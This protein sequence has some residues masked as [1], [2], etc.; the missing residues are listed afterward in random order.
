M[1]SSNHAADFPTPSRRRLAA[2]ALL[3]ALE[4]LLAI[5]WLAAIPADPKNAV[6]LGFS[7]SRLVMLI[8][9]FALAAAF[10][11]AAVWLRKAGDHL[12][13]K[14]HTWRLSHFQWAAGILFFLSIVLLVLT[15]L[16][17]Y[18]FGRY[19]ATYTRIRPVVALAFAFSLQLFALVYFTFSRG[20][21]RTWKSHYA[22]GRSGRRAFWLSAAV[23][24][25]VW[26][27]I[28]VTRI[29]VEPQ[30]EFWNSPELPVLG[31]QLLI[32]WLLTLLF[33][34]AYRRFSNRR[35]LLNLTA[36]LL[37]WA[38][39]AL[40]WHNQPFRGDFFLTQPV[41]PTYQYY[42]FSD[43]R[44]YDTSAQ[45]AVSGY[46]YGRFYVDKPLVSSFLSMLHLIAGQDFGLMARLQM[47]V[48]ALIPVLLFRIGTEVGSPSG[49]LMGALLFTAQEGNRIA[50]AQLVQTS[51]SRL[52]LSELPTALLLAGFT[53][54]LVRWVKRPDRR[55]LSMLAAG[56]ILGLATLARHNTWLMLPVGL[57]IIL[58]VCWKHR[59]RALL[60]GAVFLFGLSLAIA[61]W[62]V[63]SQ[64][65]HGT[66][67]YFTIPARGVI[68]EN[69]YLPQIETDEEP[70]T[71]VI[72]T[73]KLASTVPF[74]SPGAALSAAQPI[75]TAPT[76]LSKYG[77]LI[78]LMLRHY[79]HN[80]AGSV[81]ILPV[82]GQ[83]HDLPTTLQAPGAVWQNDWG[84]SLSLPAAIGLF[85]T[86]L[87]LSTGI[88]QAWQKSR[89]AG[90]TPLLVF[91]S[92]AGAT[93]VATTSG[94]RYLVQFSWVIPLY[95]G[96]GILWL[97][98]QALRLP[99]WLPQHGT[100]AAT[101]AG[102]GPSRNPVLWPK[103]V[104]AA[105]L[106]FAAGVWTAYGDQTLRLFR[107]PVAPVQIPV[108]RAENENL[109]AKEGRALYTQ[110]REMEVEQAGIA[111]HTHV[112]SFD[113]LN[114][115][116]LF[117]L[118]MPLK[119]EPPTWVDGSPVTV[120]G[121]QTEDRFIPVV[122]LAATGGETLALESSAPFP[123]A[124]SE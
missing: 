31:L 107:E 37:I 95:L 105:A 25:L 2:G 1:P 61:P 109:V 52:F 29:G 68:I 45:L 6:F 101:Q 64:Q 85:L 38:G 76:G 99:G 103:L 24:G 82:S 97:T 90:L 55:W 44:I 30:T 123:A 48:F 87:L 108:Q 115:D 119:E 92:Y 39:A 74:S 60:A 75:E 100:N 27:F 56:G 104:L 112:F 78:V 106:I 94:G 80:L 47:L 22:E 20:R 5:F 67:F 50:A 28:A 15:A 84:G 53:W 96:L 33:L 51:H 19:A 77:S 114:T 49:G 111:L 70:Q 54:L 7:A 63:R 93:A 26:L 110:H 113:L 42:P 124:C 13:L 57:L 36:I 3:F 8:F 88:G 9:L 66:P 43:S 83:L 58:G 21:A 71:S 23:S 10:C 17:D 14:L 34:A 117:S 81:L 121:C 59:R 16:P 79:L 122:V 89:F 41:P 120:L 69:R 98:R 35:R 102:A 62:M 4:T 86:L 32:G 12:P 72:S 40:Y 118:R 73:V 65:V 91:L 11:A 18:R 116:G 46:G